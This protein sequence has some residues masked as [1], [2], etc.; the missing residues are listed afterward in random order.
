MLRV[1][2]DQQKNSKTILEKAFLFILWPFFGPCVEK[3]YKW[4][5]LRGEIY[6]LEIDHIGY[7]KSRILC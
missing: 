1:V 4:A 7:Q 2:L 3:F 5:H 6:F